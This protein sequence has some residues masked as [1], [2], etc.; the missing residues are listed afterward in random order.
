MK[1]NILIPMA[2]KNTF[3]VSNSNAFPKVLND[4]NGK[5]LI[6]RAS[7]PFISIPYE[8]KI[9]VTLPKDQISDYKLDKI[10]TLLDS[11]I[12]ICPVNSDT[13]G[14]VCTSMLAIEQ[15]ALDQPLIISSFEQVLDLNISDFLDEFQKEDV[16]AGVLTFEGIHPKWSFVRL[17]ENGF[18]S[19]AAEK[20]PISKNAIAGF[21]YFKTASLF[22]E[23]AKEM[24]RNDVTH[25]GLFYISHTLNE[26]ILN[27]GRVLAIPIDKSKYFHINDQHSLD[28][29]EETV[30]EAS[31]QFS[32]KIYQKTVEYIEAF[33]SRSIDK[34]VSHFS[35]DFALNDPSTNLIG[36]EI[37]KEYITTLFQS[38]PNLSF[39]SDN[40]IVDG[41]R[42]VIE[43]ELTLGEGVFNGSDIIEWD[44]ENK[45]VSMNAY[46]N[47][48]K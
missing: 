9:I 23:S 1:F 6:E 19:Q 37:V 15:L 36:K 10:L 31:K 43:F 45:M 22:I 21:Y 20:S 16:D 4:I 38:N 12:E 8:K 34:V 48:K 27:Q 5:L 2:G 39:K 33:D 7:E 18:V 29:Y 28:N 3:D 30:I 44:N 14:A 42:S 25:N 47:E 46:L 35:E 32:E 17:D 11:S 26:V 13:K 41:H 40:I 24:I